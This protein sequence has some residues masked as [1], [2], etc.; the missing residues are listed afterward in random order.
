VNLGFFIR[1]RGINPKCVE[2]HRFKPKMTGYQRIIISSNFS[3]QRNAGRTR[4]SGNRATVSPRKRFD[5]V[6][7]ATF[8]KIITTLTTLVW[9]RRL[10]HIGP[11]TI[12]HLPSPV[13][14][15]KLDKGPRTIDCEVCSVS[16]AH[17]IVSRRPAP[18]ASS[19][20]ERVHIDLI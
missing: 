11:K 13:E 5:S 9:H 20:Y 1:D 16:K 3:S 14:G 18:R 7:R 15:A 8:T 12:D 2:S 6:S 4:I 19:P 17:K 10:G